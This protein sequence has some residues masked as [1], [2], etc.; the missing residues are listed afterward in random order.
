MIEAIN[1]IT[2]QNEITYDRAEWKSNE[3]GVVKTLQ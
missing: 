1:D 3:K 2:L